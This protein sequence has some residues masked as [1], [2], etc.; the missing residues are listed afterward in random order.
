MRNCRYGPKEILTCLAVNC[1]AGVIPTVFLFLLNFPIS[2][3]AALNSIVI[4]AVFANSIGFP[5]RFVIPR[6][7]P[8]VARRGPVWEWIAVALTLV[9][10]G[11]IGCLLGMVVL[12]LLGFLT[13][14][15]FWKDAQGNL[16]LCVIITLAFGLV[17]TAFSRLQGRIHQQELERERALKLA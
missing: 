6:L 1:V 7:Y 15:S 9:G 3:K 17:I 5:A 4:G 16:L 11:L 12:T 14:S 10:L 2:R 8:G 13:W